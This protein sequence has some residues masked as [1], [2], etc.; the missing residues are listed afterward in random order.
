M[1]ALGCGLAACDSKSAG[2]GMPLPH[3]HAIGSLG[4]IPGR[5]AMPRA[6]DTDGTALWVIDKTARVQRIDPATGDC[7]FWFQMPDWE[8]G[9]PVGVTVAPGD[10]VIPGVPGASKVDQARPILFIPDTHYNRVMIYRVPEKKTDPPELLG[11]F[12]T[13][14][15]GPG[16]FIYP[17]SILLTTRPAAGGGEELE[18]IY[19]AEY[20]G[21]DRISVFDAHFNFLSSFG[22]YGDSASPEKIEFARPQT[23]RWRDGG[24]GREMV[25]T[26]A[27]NHRI[28]RFTPEGKLLGWI[29]SPETSGHAPGQLTFPYGLW[30]LKDGTALIAEF[31]NNRVQRMNVET[32]AC[33][34]TWGRAGRG[35]GE[36]ASPWSLA[37]MDGEVFVVDSGNNRVIRFEGP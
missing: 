7:L 17:T 18:K 21:N 2:A 34:G 1:A 30:M 14:G 35:P 4:D 22:S 12:G 10:L 9:K 33:L 23:M 25:V 11:R 36:L 3:A 19:V 13:Y 15:M 27:R 6:I 29:G 26:D 31:G 5:F 28:G 37:V 32:G 20:G 16:Q 8:L 24:A